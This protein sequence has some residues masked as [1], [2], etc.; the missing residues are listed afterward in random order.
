MGMGSKLITSQ[1]VKTRDFDAIAARVAQCLGWVRAARGAKQP[2][3]Q[4]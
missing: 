2:V 3:A 4:R 1:A